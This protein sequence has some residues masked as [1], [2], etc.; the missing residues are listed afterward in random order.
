MPREPALGR[1]QLADIASPGNRLPTRPASEAGRRGENFRSSRATG[2]T[3]RQ[4]LRTNVPCSRDGRGVS[5]AKR[6]PAATRAAVAGAGRSRKPA[7]PGGTRFEKRRSVPRRPRKCGR[8]ASRRGPSRRSGPA[9]GPSR[10][11]AA[12]VAPRALRGRPPRREG[13]ERPEDS[14]PSTQPQATAGAHDIRRGR[15]R[16]PASSGA[17]TASTAPCGGIAVRR[18]PAVGVG[19]TVVPNHDPM[20][21]PI[22]S[23]S[24]AIR[25]NIQPARPSTS[26]RSRLQREYAQATPRS[27]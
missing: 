13:E 7:R 12:A 19:K 18:R 23:N 25:T 17:R 20:R 16:F 11:Q 26:S 2:R 15:R 1:S 27:A 5:L 3:R 22:A 10:R 21:S 24:R 4:R 8:A 14:V 6:Q 9:L